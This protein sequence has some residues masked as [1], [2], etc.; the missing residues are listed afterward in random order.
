MGVLDETSASEWLQPV[1]VATW[2]LAEIDQWK[3]PRAT[4]LAA[5]PDHVRARLYSPRERSEMFGR[6]WGKTLAFLSS[7]PAHTPVAT[8]SMTTGGVVLATSRRKQV[9]GSRS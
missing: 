9:F 2:V 8:R 4:T 7:V 1:D 5:V 6:R 3:G